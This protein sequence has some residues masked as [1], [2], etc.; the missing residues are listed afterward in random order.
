M[1]FATRARRVRHALKIVVLRVGAVVT[2]SAMWA[3][4]RIVLRALLIVV[5]SYHKYVTARSCLVRRHVAMVCVRTRTMKIVKHVP[6]IVS[7]QRV[8]HVPRGAALTHVAMDVVTPQKTRTAPVALMT[9]GARMGRSV[10][11]AAVVLHVET[12]L[13]MIHKGKNV[14]LVL[15]IV[16][17]RRAVRS[18][19]MVSVRHLVEMVFVRSRARRIVI[20]VQVIVLVHHSNIATL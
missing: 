5:V 7:A 17:V 9:V 20:P 18:A 16:R 8:E 10:K 3:L 4:E 1:V 15:L 11:M 12:G 14:P 2:V 19:R 6:E 13:A